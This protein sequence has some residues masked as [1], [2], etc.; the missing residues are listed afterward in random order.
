MTTRCRLANRTE[1]KLDTTIDRAIGFL[2]NSAQQDIVEKHR[3][4]LNYPIVGAA[5]FTVSKPYG[6]LS[7]WPR[8]RA[9][10]V[11]DHRRGSPPLTPVRFSAPV[12]FD[13]DAT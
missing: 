5:N 4:R 11:K 3:V 10:P 9:F 13:R 1:I 6:I 7:R 12:D 2:E 8:R